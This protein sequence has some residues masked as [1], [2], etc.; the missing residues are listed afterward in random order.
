MLSATCLRWNECLL[1]SWN[2]KQ[3]SQQFPVQLLPIQYFSCWMQMSSNVATASSFFSFSWDLLF[4]LTVSTP[5]CWSTCPCKS[6]WQAVAELRGQTGQRLETRFANSSWFFWVNLLWE[7]PVLSCVLWKD[8]SMSTKRA[9]S[10][11]SR[12]R[13]YTGVVCRFQGSVQFGFFA[14]FFH[15]E[16][17]ACGEAMSLWWRILESVLGYVLPKRH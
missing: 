8:S 2:Y 11:V 9:R 3:V 1:Q 4:P 16:S 15:W 10:E 5:C 17:L 14:A 6:P 7:S 12:V 13:C